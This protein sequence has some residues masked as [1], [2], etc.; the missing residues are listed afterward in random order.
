MRVGSLE[1]MPSQNGANEVRPCGVS[2]SLPGTDHE[3]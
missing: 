1:M 2:R 3:Y